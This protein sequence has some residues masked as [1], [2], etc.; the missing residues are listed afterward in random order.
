MRNNNENYGPYILINVNQHQ[1]Y[2]KILIPLLAS[3]CNCTRGFKKCEHNVF[4]CIC[5]CEFGRLSD[6][7][8]GLLLSK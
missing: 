1:R 4:N 6:V 3:T 8:H 2:M 7:T 5:L